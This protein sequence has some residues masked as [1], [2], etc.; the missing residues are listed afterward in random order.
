MDQ[1]TVATLSRAATARAVL[2]RSRRRS[3]ELADGVFR[4][5][6]PREARAG[7]RHFAV[8]AILLVAADAADELAVSLAAIGRR[9]VTKVDGAW[10]TASP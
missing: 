6:D 3:C 9:P 4:A 7:G 10:R 2:L 8:A 1:G 5:D